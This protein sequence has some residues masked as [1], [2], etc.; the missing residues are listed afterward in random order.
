L[1][2]GDQR[3]NLGAFLERVTDAQARH[4]GLEQGQEVIEDVTLDQDP[5]TGRSMLPSGAD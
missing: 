4:R 1:H 3:A 5:G 2:G